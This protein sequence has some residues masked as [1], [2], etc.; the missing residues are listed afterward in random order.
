M[1]TFEFTLDGPPVSTQTRSRPRLKAWKQRVRR[2]AESVWPPEK[3][4]VD[5]EVSLKITYFF[6]GPSGDV[7]NYIKPIQDALVGVAY[8]DDSLVADVSSRKS[9]LDGAFRIKGVSPEVALKLA[10]GDDFLWIRMLH[11]PSHEELL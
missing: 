5:Y 10:K 6:D 1:I 11:Q 9:R 2:A 4:P 3:D 8:V 7:D